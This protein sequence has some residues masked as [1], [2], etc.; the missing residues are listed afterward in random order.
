MMS[1]TARHTP[2]E[3]HDMQPPTG[4]LTPYRKTIRQERK[5]E[6]S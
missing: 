5:V 2:T 6:A 4:T 3:E 1:P